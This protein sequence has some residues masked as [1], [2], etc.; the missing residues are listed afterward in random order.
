M[1]QV[2]HKILNTQ[3]FIR[4][5]F[6]IAYDIVAVILSSYIP[7]VMRYEFRIPQIP[8]QFMDNVKWF[9]PF[10]IVLTLLTFY[11][12]RLYHSLWAYAGVTEM[13][14]MMAACAVSA[15]CQCIGLHFTGHYVPRSYYFIYLLVLFAFTLL[16]RFSYRFLREAK[17]RMVNS[18]NGTAVMIIGAGDAG[19]VIMKEIIGSYYSTMTIKCVIDDDKNKWGRYVQGIRVIGGREQI[20]SAAKRYG[21]DQIIIALPSVPK[22]I[23]RDII[24]ICKETDCKLRTLPGM[25]QLVNGE[26]NVSKIRDVDV[27]DLLGREPIKVDLNSILEYV[28]DKVVLVTGGG[29][30][31][32]SEL[33]R[34]I[35]THQPKQ[36]II[37]DIYENSA[38]DI[39]QELLATHPRMNLLVLIASVRNTARMSSIFE[40]YHPDIVYHAAAHKH[41]PLM[42][43]SPNEAIKNN[44]F[45]TWKTA[46]AAAMN[47]VK[48]FV[49]ISTDKAV[50]PTN[51]MGASKRICEM[52]IQTFNR[53]YETE[54]VAVRF[55]NVLGSNGSVIPLFRR[56]I[57]SGGPVTVTHPDIIRYFMTIPE[58]V[59]LVLQAGVY[60]RGGEIFVLDMGEPVKILDLAK[61][62][63]RLSGYK[64]DEDIKIIFTGLRP[65]EKLYEEL[66]M[67][68]EGMTDTANKL[69]HIG[70]PIEFDEMVFF[71]QLKR[72]KEAANEESD[73]IREIVREIVPTYTPQGEVW[74]EV[75]HEP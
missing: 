32:G 30:S 41:V 72:L 69:I 12:L 61:N 29:G 5:A 71:G 51:I 8:Q 34:Q 39:Q 3:L 15:L 6:L 42:E 70:K 44:V 13:Q 66:L 25:Y 60:A 21:I 47:G 62:L 50:N 28:K 14:N 43:V 40:T 16:S 46:Q 38:Y 23:I 1:K 67:N 74:H 22:H 64:V 73:D 37:V 33:C 9:L 2:E 45:G 27:E 49:M 57:E 58:A 75:E 19:N 56:Q 48:K 26:V 10:G 63:I 65:G 31:I 7:L 68:E 54:F 18:K 17:H 36:L 55:G 59:S 35:A 24:N 4:R 53:H 52:I 11:L 20:L